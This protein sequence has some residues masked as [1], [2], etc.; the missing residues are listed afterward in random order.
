[1]A[2][3]PFHNPLL[4]EA[5]YEFTKF[6]DTTH[7]IHR[8]KELEVPIVSN[9]TGEVVFNHG[10]AVDKFIDGFFNPVLFFESVQ[11]VLKQDGDFTLASFGPNSKVNQ[12]LFQKTD[13]S[14][15]IISNVGL[16]SHDDIESFASTLA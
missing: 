9:L 11:Q 7:P 1:M 14:K 2:Q 6:I 10:D 5:A 8:S 3:V 12:S 13:I 15:K 4:E 16:E